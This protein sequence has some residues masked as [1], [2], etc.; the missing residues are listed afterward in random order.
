MANPRTLVRQPD[1][2]SRRH[3]VRDAAE[4]RLESAE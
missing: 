2:L 1:A 4:R 3:R